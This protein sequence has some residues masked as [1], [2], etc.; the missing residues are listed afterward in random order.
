MS[1]YQDVSEYTKFM[2]EHAGVYIV[3]DN[4]GYIRERK[5]DKVVQVDI[6]NEKKDLICFQE[7]VQ[8][9]NALI[10]NLFSEGIGV[11]ADQNWFYSMMA[12]L[13]S[14]K[15]IDTWRKV[16]NVV[17]NQKSDDKVDLP[18]DVVKLI[19]PYMNTVTKS[20]I[21]DI[22]KI[23]SNQVKLMTV[24]YQAKTK[25]AKYRCALFE[26]PDFRDV[27]PKAAKKTWAFIEELTGQLLGID[28]TKPDKDKLED[29]QYKSSILG[30]PM[31]D[32]YS[33]LYVELYKR[34]NPIFKI[35]DSLP[36]PLKRNMAYEVDV[37]TFEKHM[38]KL[39]EYYDT[40]KGLIQSNVVSKSSKPA[41]NSTPTITNKIVGGGIPK[42]TVPGTTIPLP[43]QRMTSNI[44]MPYQNSHIPSPRLVNQR[45]GSGHAMLVNT[46]HSPIGHIGGVAG[47]YYQPV[48]DIPRAGVEMNPVLS[49]NPPLM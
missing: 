23:S 2:V 19:S 8:D 22:N 41:Q 33:H 43:G 36:E 18:M 49:N 48:G 26:G 3:D 6:N 12:S 9:P 29:L 39:D 30:Y 31:L 28:M 32:A 27:Y 34:T 5:T 17:I 35:L 45:S 13:F 1:K 37:E 21:A 10:L 47:A 38:E 4:K 20:C 24:F 15:V 16:A 7:L 46:T 44:P 25:T 14:F 40:A 11:T 42:P